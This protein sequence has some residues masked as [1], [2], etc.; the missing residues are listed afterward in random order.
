MDGNGTK[1]T[2]TI[3]N[4]QEIVNPVNQNHAGKN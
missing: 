3:P 1:K 4:K 2:V